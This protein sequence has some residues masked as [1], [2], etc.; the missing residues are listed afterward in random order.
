MKRGV[1]ILALIISVVVEVVV[2]VLLLN[3]TGD[4]GQDTIEINRCLNAVEE[5][6]KK[7]KDSPDGDL[8][9]SLEK[10]SDPYTDALIF[11]VLD[12]ENNVLYKNDP[13]AATSIN[14]AIR[15]HD[16][17]LNLTVDGSVVGRM[18]FF[19][20]T[21]WSTDKYRMG[22]LVCISIISVILAVVFWILS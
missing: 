6:Y 11:T 1:I 12:N 10:L 21:V 20:D 8:A 15:N 19:N 16:T 3:Q 14:E 18:V 9:G 4:T 17:I 13:K 7:T 2:S 5:E 22:I